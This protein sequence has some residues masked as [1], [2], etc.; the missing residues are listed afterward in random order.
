MSLYHFQM[1]KLLHLSFFWKI[2]KL[3]MDFFYML[4]VWNMNYASPFKIHVL[5]YKVYVRFLQFTQQLGD[6]LSIMSINVA[7][8]HK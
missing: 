4:N 1:L 2:C 8:D 5:D 7:N 6:F 3:Y